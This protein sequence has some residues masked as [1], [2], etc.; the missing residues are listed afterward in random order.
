MRRSRLVISSQSRSRRLQPARPISAHRVRLRPS[1]CSARSTGIRM[2]WRRC[3]C[4]ARCTRWHSR[5]P[6]IRS[7][8]A[9]TPIRTCTQS[10][11]KCW[12]WPSSP[13]PSR[14]SA[15]LLAG[16]R[17]L[18]PRTTPHFALAPSCSRSC[19]RRARWRSERPR[20]TATQRILCCSPPR[21]GSWRL[22]PGTTLAK[23][24]LWRKWSSQRSP[25]R[26]TTRC[27]PP[28]LP[29]SNRPRALRA[30]ELRARRL[31]VT[32]ATREVETRRHAACATT[33]GLSLYLWRSSCINFFSRILA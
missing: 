27:S 22:S 3:R 4:C 13:T 2:G 5:C 28:P 26:R 1:T 24:V 7:S 31:K 25:F 10:Q 17:L 12:A 6:T 15:M 29:Y 19:R 8:L 32:R 20:A 11:A 14:P 33:H 18:A 23:G 30:N 9:S 21:S 16:E